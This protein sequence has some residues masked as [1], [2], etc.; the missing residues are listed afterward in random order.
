[1]QPPPTSSVRLSVITF[2]T[3]NILE[4]SLAGERLFWLNIGSLFIVTVA[5][6]FNKDKIIYLIYLGVH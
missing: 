4:L 3:Q 5:C 6:H 2:S 1:M